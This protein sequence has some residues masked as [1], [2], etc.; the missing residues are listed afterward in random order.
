MLERFARE[1]RRAAIR[2]QDAARLVG[3][4]QVEPEHLLLALSEG[5]DP[6]GRA[7]A[8]VGVNRAAIEEAIEED[9]VATLQ[10]VGVPPSVVASTPAHPRRDRPGFS[11]QAKRALEQALHEAVRRGDRRLGTEH[12]LLGVLRRPGAT[13]ARVLVRLDVDPERLA[14]L[15]Q[16]E[17]AAQR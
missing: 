3:A 5:D 1:S 6:A 9:L 15:V 4:E 13:V 2:A 12:V 10:V 14:A 16:V 17:A 11:V 8:E 7:L